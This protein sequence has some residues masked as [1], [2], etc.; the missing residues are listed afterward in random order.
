M[1]SL[2]RQHVLGEKPAAGSFVPLASVAPAS[3]PASGDEAEE[4]ASTNRRCA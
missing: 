3:P 1:M 4:S 2:Y